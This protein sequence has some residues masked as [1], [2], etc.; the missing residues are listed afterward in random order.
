[1]TVNMVDMM[2]LTSQENINI[3]YQYVAIVEREH[4]VL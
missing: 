3:H 2:P 4:N 1:M